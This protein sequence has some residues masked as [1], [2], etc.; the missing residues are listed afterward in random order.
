MLLYSIQREKEGLD[1]RYGSEDRLV[2]QQMLEEI[3]RELGTNLHYLAEIDAFN[4]KGA[5]KIM[6]KYVDR[7][8]SEDVR[9]HCVP[10]LVEDRIPDCDAVLLALYHHFQD[11]SE[12]FPVNGYLS[13]HVY[14]RYDNAFTR[15]KSKRCQ[16]DLLELVQNPINMFYLPFTVEMLSSWTIPVLYELLLCYARHEKS[17]PPEFQEALSQEQLAFAY[18]QIMFTVISGFRYFPTEEAKAILSD[19]SHSEDRD[20][21]QAAKKS[22][23]LQQ[24]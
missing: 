24:R 13:A 10:Q 8:Q 6:C 3:N 1:Y 11:S 21:R 17:F 12:F 9:A 15:R 14:V 7:F 16:N 4:L 23:R 22:Q 5:G 2:L 19:C 18:R 20:I